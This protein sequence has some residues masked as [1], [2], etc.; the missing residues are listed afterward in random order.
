MKTLSIVLA[1]LGM[2]L[3][4]LAEAAVKNI[5]LVHGAFADGSGWRPVATILERDGYTVYVV[6]EPLTSWDAD[7]AATRN[8]LD[9]AGPCVLVAHS[10]GGMIITEVGDRPSVRSLVYVAA[11]EPDV[12]ETAGALQAKNPPA[13]G[14]SV[15]PSGGGFVYVN[16]AAFDKDFAAGVP[17]ATAHFMAISQVPIAADSFGAKVTVAAWSKKPSFAVIPSKD[18]QINPGPR[19]IHGQQSQVRDA[20]A[21]RK[22]RDISSAPQGGRG[23]YRKGGPDGEMTSG[24][25]ALIPMEEQRKS[26]QRIRH[27]YPIV[28]KGEQDMK[29]ARLLLESFWCA[30]QRGRGGAS[31]SKSSFKP[32]RGFHHVDK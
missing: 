1:V 31:Q 11:F 18:R 12:G 7:L 20:R 26:L 2:A 6:Q 30:E 17:E 19:T 21:P 29:T 4:P 13:G 23:A 25:R 27:S 15:V 9:R 8:V 32:Y 3:T 22:P 24:S 28:I 10:W 16:P 14:Q 5:V